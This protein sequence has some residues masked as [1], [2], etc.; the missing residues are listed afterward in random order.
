[1]VASAPDAPPVCKAGEC[2]ARSESETLVASSSLKE[3]GKKERLAKQ[4][5]I[6]PIL[7]FAGYEW[8][9]FFAL[10]AWFIEGRLAITLES[11]LE[12]WVTSAVRFLVVF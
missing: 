3:E 4:E 11:G 1:M 10:F 6:A 9:C 8:S 2:K 7:K 5:Q 12:A